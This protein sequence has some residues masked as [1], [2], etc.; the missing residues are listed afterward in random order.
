MSAQLQNELSDRV[1]NA[2]NDWARTDINNGINDVWEAP[3][4]GMKEP[5]SCTPS[6][7]LRLIDPLE[8]FRINVGEFLEGNCRSEDRILLEVNVL[9][10]PL[11]GIAQLELVGA[12]FDLGSIGFLGSVA[13]LELVR[14]VLG[15]G[16]R[17]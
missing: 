6:Y 15:I 12:V 5:A 8:L 14:A 10:R 1:S 16:S 3:E 4:R 9:D 2:I 13:Q 7:D 17:R 11:G